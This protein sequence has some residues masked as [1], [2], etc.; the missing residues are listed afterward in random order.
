[1]R[2][3]SAVRLLA[4]FWCATLAAF[5]QDLASFEKRVT[6]K[7]LPNGLTIVLCQR[8][9]APVFSYFTIVD[10]GSANDPGGESGLA[11]MFEHLAFKG[12]KDIGTTDYAAEKVALDKVEKAYAAYDT[13]SLKRVGRDP[14]KLKQ[15]HA[16]FEQ[17]V[18][19][20][21]KY[22]I[23]NQFTEIAEENGAVGLNAETSLDATQYFWSMP[24][25]RLQLW[26]YLES[27]RIANPVPREFY[28][29]RDVVM[30]ER[31]MRVDSSPIGRMVEQFLATAYMA[32]PYRRP[33]VGWAS[34]LSHITATE[35]DAFHKEYYVPSNIVIAVVGDVDPAQAMPV[36]EKYFGAIPAGPKPPEMT[37]V[38]PPQTAEK[39]V[40]IQEPTQPLYL[41]GYHRPDYRD[42]DD[43]VYDAIQDIFS[44]GR[45]S[46]L[47]R[48]LVRD[49]KIAVEAEGFSGFPGD[50]YPGLFAFFAVPAPG[51]TPQEMRT[52]IH[53]E[54]D[55]LKT[56]DV[57]DEEL[58]MFKTRARADILRGLADN[59]GL[60]EQLATYQL[61]YGDWRELFNQLKRIDA[62]SKAD[63]R[64]V[65][66]KTFVP[67]NRTYTMVEFHA[68][69]QARQTKGGA[70]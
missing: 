54:I 57:S 45:T 66:N 49:Q 23:P 40:V 20:A 68:P 58:A 30:E 61:R 11:H 34:E 19:E 15:L 55:R 70:Q 22:V 47:Y 21:Q 59:Q 36:L 33:G 26:A 9:E 13:E 3:S 39:S 50:K 37:T 6:T 42:P 2:F 51:H 48:S 35:A 24:S 29:E 69:E 65:A 46:R 62:V 32:H 60:A 67:T 64:R 25:N 8:P 38:E 12:T 31:R 43:A 44:N 14:E 17:A 18:A 41:E 53:K 27:D 52:A 63:I 4:L 28:K 5:A 16:A 10:A 1:M 7:V 56:T